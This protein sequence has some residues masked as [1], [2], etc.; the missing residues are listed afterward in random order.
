MLAESGRRYYAVTQVDGEGAKLLCN[1][2]SSLKNSV[3]NSKG[4]TRCCSL[5]V[6]L[7]RETDAHIGPR[8]KQFP[9][10]LV[11]Q[12]AALLHDGLPLTAPPPHFPRWKKGMSYS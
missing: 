8:A 7:H 4:S 5:C 3:I 10:P 6:G 9:G 2:C 12:C 1:F 11:T